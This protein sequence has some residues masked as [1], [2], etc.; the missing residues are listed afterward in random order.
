MSVIVFTDPFLNTI[1]TQSTRPD[2]AAEVAQPYILKLPPTKKRRVIMAYL[3][4]C[5]REFT[6]V[7]SRGV[8]AVGGAL[9]WGTGKIKAQTQKGEET[10]RRAKERG[11]TGE[12]RSI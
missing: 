3:G 9:W 8:S 4:C 11:I 6:R 10:P 7:W 12:T 2:H 1:A 5:C